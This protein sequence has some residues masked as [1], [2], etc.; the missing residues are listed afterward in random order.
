MKNLRRLIR[1]VI[2]QEA[3]LRPMRR[4]ELSQKQQWDE[5]A[6][7]ITKVLQGIGK[8]FGQSR[9]GRHS[10]ELWNDG[11][12]PPHIDK[13]GGYGNPPMIWIRK[14][15]MGDRF[16]QKAQIKGTSILEVGSDLH[17]ESFDVYA[18]LEI[19]DIVA[20][21]GQALFEIINKLVGELQ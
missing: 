11:P 8:P 13:G 5:V 17:G 15:D 9:L 12:N 2:L 6:R 7:I 18:E 1:K 3:G 16:D 4:R 19:R 20:D 14:G 10:A 21:N